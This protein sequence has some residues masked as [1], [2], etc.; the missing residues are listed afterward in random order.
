MPSQLLQGFWRSELWSSCLQASALFSEPPPSLTL[1]HLLLS[2]FQLFWVILCLTLSLFSKPAGPWPGLGTSHLIFDHSSLPST[3][4]V[5]R[6]DLVGHPTRPTIFSLSKA[7]CLFSTLSC[8]NA[9]SSVC[10]ESPEHPAPEPLCLPAFMP[11]SRNAPV[12]FLCFL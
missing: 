12:D 4:Q 2:S 1:F 10:K 3:L 7:F 11:C 9:L 6:V 8:L 5:K